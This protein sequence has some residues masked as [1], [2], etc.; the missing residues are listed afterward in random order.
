MMARP[1]AIK[2]M[3]QT[4]T[5]RYSEAVGEINNSRPHFISSFEN[6]KMISCELGMI[7]VHIFSARLPLML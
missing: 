3:A 5:I 7:G 2:Q 1:I 4:S 6:I